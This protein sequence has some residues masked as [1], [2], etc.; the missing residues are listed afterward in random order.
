VRSIV[1]P[2]GQ[3]ASGAPKWAS[4]GRPRPADNF[5]YDFSTTLRRLINPY[6][7]GLVAA[8]CNGNGEQY[9]FRRS[10]AHGAASQIQ[11]EGV[12]ARRLARSL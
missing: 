5:V 7:R 3:Q 10:A 12:A 9:R 8:F 11:A 1:P 2:V 6:T 4:Y